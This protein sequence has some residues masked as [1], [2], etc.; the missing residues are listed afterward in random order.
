MNRRRIPRFEP[1]VIASAA[2]KNWRGDDEK[3]ATTSIK[4][5]DLDGVTISSRYDKA[6]EYE[7]MASMI[8]GVAPHLRS[9]IESLWCDSKA[10]A[11]YSVTL[12]PCSLA[13]AREI[14]RQ[15]EEACLKYGSGH[16]GITVEG[17]RGRSLD[18]D[19]NWLGDDD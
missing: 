11:C 18:I 13:Q 5:L 1:E 10:T 3:V 17:T 7:M 9:L 8:E 14:G 12:R 15:L 4:H 6:D 2:R 19:P 16:N